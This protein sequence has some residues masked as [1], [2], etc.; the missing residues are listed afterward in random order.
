M[1]Q[2][3]HKEY[4]ALVDG[5]PQ[6]RVGQIEG[7]IG[8]D[9]RDRKKMAIVPESRGRAAATLYRTAETFS[10][11]ALL[12]VEPKTGRTHQIRVHL[13]SIG[14]PIAGDTTYGRRKPTLKLNRQFLHARR[15]KFRLP[16]SVQFMEFEAP[17]PE[18][19]AVVLEAL[20]TEDQ[21]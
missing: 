20:R 16:D 21:Q 13:A 18:E 14:V 12:A 9:P 8:R 6:N 17:L 5:H 7:A 1:R 2:E 4:S 19:L 3:I 10:E 11:H 15:L